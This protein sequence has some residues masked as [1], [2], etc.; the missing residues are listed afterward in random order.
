[1][2]RTGHIVGYGGAFDNFQETGPLARRV[3]DLALLMPMLGGPD[4]WDAAMAPVP[5]GDPAAVDLKTLR[6]AFYTTNGAVDPTPELQATVTQ[7]VGLLPQARR[8]GHRG[9]SRRR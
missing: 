6:V 4:D 3:E 5:L 1:M 9:P 2:P 7:T 8:E